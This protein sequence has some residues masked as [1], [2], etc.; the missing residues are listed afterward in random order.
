MLRRQWSIGAVAI[1]II[2]LLSGSCERQASHQSTAGPFISKLVCSRDGSA[3]C[4]AVSDPLKTNV[5]LVCV[6]PGSGTKEV[7]LDSNSLLAATDLLLSPDGKTAYFTSMPYQLPPYQQWLVAVDLRTGVQRKVRDFD[8]RDYFM[9][10]PEGV[11]P[12][13]RIICAREHINGDLSDPL[14]GQETDFVSVGKDGAMTALAPRFGPEMWKDLP[15]SPRFLGYA[16]RDLIIGIGPNVIA[17]PSGRTA[18]TLGDARVLWRMPRHPYATAVGAGGTVA[19]VVPDNDSTPTAGE[20]GS[21]R[22][23]V[24]RQGTTTE[25]AHGTLAS[26]LAFSPDGKRLVLVDLGAGKLQIY[27]I[28]AQRLQPGAVPP[29]VIKGVR[30]AQWLTNDSVA[31]ST[32]EVCYLYHLDGRLEQIYVVGS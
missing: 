3:A 7:M 4:L 20:N 6:R 13:D 21:Q 18:G 10:T 17:W 9:T 32:H 29:S 8:V 12:D 16:G 23:L 24:M 14:S 5:Q 11:A 28:A 27:D 19:A 30:Q 1:I 2:G 22:V 26:V 15:Q 31:F 25:A